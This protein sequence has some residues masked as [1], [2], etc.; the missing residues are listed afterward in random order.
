MDDVVRVLCEA[1]K[2]LVA[3][4]TLYEADLEL[5]RVSPTLR[6]KMKGFLLNQRAALDHLAESV[7][8]APVMVGEEIHYPFASES[9]GFD[10]SIDK[11]M[12]GVRAARPEV[13]AVVAAHQPFSVPALAHLRHLLTDQFAL[14]LLPE[15]EE[16]P[17]D[18]AASPEAAEAPVEVPVVRDPA[19]TAGGVTLSGGHYINGV[20]LDPITLQ[21]EQAARQ[22]Q[23]QEVYLA[24]RFTGRDTTALADL[25]AIDAAVRAVLVDVAAAAGLA[26][27]AG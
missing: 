8:A 7:V 9:D 26:S 4:G 16:R 14:K 18:A 13:A 17:A 10:A 20:S 27:P 1:D 24:W 12:P 3:I 21:R 19:T 5:Q 15:L 23:S 2:Q 25:A 22:R 11:N 6:G